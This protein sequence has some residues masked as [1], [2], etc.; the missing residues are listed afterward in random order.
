LQF[1]P[2][3]FESSGLAIHPRLCILDG[4]KELPAPFD[5]ERHILDLSAYRLHSVRLVCDVEILPRTLANVFPEDEWAKPIGT[6]LI[7][8]RCEPT[9][10]RRGRIVV[11]GELTVGHHEI[12]IELSHDE[13]VGSATLTPYLLRGTD[14]A[15]VD[16]Y[17]STRGHRIAAGRVAEV[18]F[19]TI[20]PPTGEY[21]DIRYESF[22]TK[23]PPQFPN[24]DA[25]YKLECD[26]EAPILWLNS[27]HERVCAVLDDAANVGRMARMRDV[28]FDQISQSVWLRLFMRAARDV[29]DA[30]EAVFS[31][32]DAVL[33][34]L[35]PYVYPHVPDQ[36]SRISTLVD[37]LRE[38]NE[39]DLLDRLDGGLQE[40]LEIGKHTTAL[41]EEI[42]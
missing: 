21:L 18:R 9:R 30:G 33:A 15:E 1:L 10:L 26:G 42:A 23:G 32:Q 4:N 17:A 27:D 5:E 14:R 38:G 40:W 34:R 2:Y 25:L 8:T 37:D 13:I 20:R 22:K 7:V 3:R 41:A 12:A 11:A 16:Q 36:E 29:A 6:L 31:W 39:H 35:L 24:V 28:L 19:E